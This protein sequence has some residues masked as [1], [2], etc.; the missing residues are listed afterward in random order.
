M[1]KK[2]KKEVC[3][4]STIG[5]MVDVVDYFSPKACELKLKSFRPFG[6]SLDLRLVPSASIYQ[7]LVYSA[8][9]H[10]RFLLTF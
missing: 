10:H 9:T 5:F 7:T 6:L 8:I 3:V 4:C 1:L 2:K